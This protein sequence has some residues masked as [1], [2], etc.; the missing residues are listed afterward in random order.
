MNPKPR[1]LRR[2]RL[3]PSSEAGALCRGCDEIGM[4]P[5][6][7]FGFAREKVIHIFRCRLDFFAFLNSFFL[8]FRAHAR[9]QSGKP[10]FMR[11]FGGFLVICILTF[12]ESSLTNSETA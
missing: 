8:F 9:G 4:V 1:F 3:S 12:S 11:V 7:V 10:L 2:S 6:F 5:R